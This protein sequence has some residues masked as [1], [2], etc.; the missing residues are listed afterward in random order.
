MNEAVPSKLTHVLRNTQQQQTQ[1]NVVQTTTTKKNDP[2]AIPAIASSVK[3]KS[4]ES[5]KIRACTVRLK[6]VHSQ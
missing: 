1:H 5:S 4:A 6:Y 3:T 2:T